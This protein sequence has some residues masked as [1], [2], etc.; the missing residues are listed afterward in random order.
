MNDSALKRTPL[1]AEHI[2]L[3]ARMVPF[4]GY[5]MPVYYGGIIEEHLAVRRAAGLFDVSH[6]GEVMVRGSKAAA[7]IQHLVSNDLSKLDDG[8]AMYS[9]MCREDGGIVD[10]LLVYRMSDVEYMLVINAANV[11]GDVAWM[12][13]NNQVH[14]DLE[15]IS[16]ETALI[17]IQGPKAFS[18]VSKVAGFSLDDLA[19]YRFMIPPR[20]AF[21]GF[22]RVILSH[23]GYTG[24]SGLE[25]YCHP[26]QAS[27]VWSALMEAGT[28]SGLVATGLGAR[29]TLRLEAGYCL[30]GNDIT[31]ETNP[32]EAGLGWVTKLDKDFVGSDTLR[33]VK[34]AG[35]K[36]RLVAFILDERGVPR[37]GH[38]I[39]DTQGRVIGEVTSGTQSPVLGKGIG[40]GYVENEPGFTTPGS[41][42]TILNRGRALSAT[43][44]RPPLHKT[45]TD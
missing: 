13:A 39:A 11:E 25:I 31:T 4:A 17:A 29:D 32:L 7:F 14:A 36:R 23:T 45:A 6:M 37:H 19:Y 1:H 22:D 8:K 40:M 3:G 43:I 24:E 10:D 18:I 28:P 27:A 20:G 35:V 41:K 44:A 16:E 5:D 26:S 9:V 2:A 34:A 33:A 38:E 21:M 42:I 15:D 12:R 30:Y